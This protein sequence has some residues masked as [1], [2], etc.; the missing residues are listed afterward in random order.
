M[1]LEY[2]DGV[3][4][5]CLLL[6]L[7]D[8]Q[9]IIIYSHFYIALDDADETHHRSAAALPASP[10]G[11]SAVSC[12]YHVAFYNHSLHPIVVVL[13]WGSSARGLWC[14][15]VMSAIFHWCTPRHGLSLSCCRANFVTACRVGINKELPPGTNA[16]RFVLRFVFILISQFLVQ[17][18]CFPCPILRSGPL[19]ARVDGRAR[20]CGCIVFC[21]PYFLPGTVPIEFH[22]L[23]VLFPF[24]PPH[25][26]VEIV[27]LR[28]GRRVALW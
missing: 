17:R 13:K 25:R 16:Y 14:F 8:L 7:H 2:Y 26:S 22:S 11:R 24:D 18:P 4:L 12:P 10:P 1:Y 21:R 3:D 6:Y 5:V 20:C 15:T 9:F 28:C 27:A 23:L 19:D